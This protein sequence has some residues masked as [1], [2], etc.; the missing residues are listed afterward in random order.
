MDDLTRS[1]KQLSLSEK[2]G[3]KLALAKN[4]KRVEFV[5]AAKFL[6]KRKVSVMQWLK[7]LDH[8]GIRVV[9]SISVM[10]VTIIYSSP[11][12]LNLI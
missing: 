2:E 6:T 3:K 8:Y 10:C 11:L 4:K 9:I 12:N 1:W 5:L 7:H